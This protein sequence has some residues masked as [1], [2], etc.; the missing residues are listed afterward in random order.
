MKKS[1]FV[2]T[3]D[4]AKKLRTAAERISDLS[5]RAA[6]TDLF[7]LGLYLRKTGNK[8]AGYKACDV[9]LRALPLNETLSKKIL[10]HLDD[11]NAGQL[12]AKFHAHSEFRSL[13]E[14]WEE[15]AVV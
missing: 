12:A 8:E 13:I 4:E 14:N 3:V 9:A 2:L 11:A 6:V 7:A 5:V 1:S 15:T 10:S